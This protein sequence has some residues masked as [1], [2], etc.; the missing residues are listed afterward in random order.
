MD[1]QGCGCV[2]EGVDEGPLDAGA[3]VGAKPGQ[4]LTPHRQATGL[5]HPQDLGLHPPQGHRQAK[6]DRHLSFSQ[7]APRLALATGPQPC[8]VVL[9]CRRNHCCGKI[10]G[11]PPALG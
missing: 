1:R 10:K 7:M 4:S 6:G 9:L 2:G 5:I 11:V 8:L 3:G